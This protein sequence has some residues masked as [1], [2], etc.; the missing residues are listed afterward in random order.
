MHRSK[1]ENDYVDL[2]CHLRLFALLHLFAKCIVRLL[3]SLLHASQPV[4][5][6]LCVCCCGR[7][8]RSVNLKVVRSKREN[9]EKTNTNDTN[10]IA[11]IIVIAFRP[12]EMSAANAHEWHC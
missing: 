4:V 7:F 2:I 3:C 5:F 9:I 8:T 10:S 1:R 12:S 6:V 11:K